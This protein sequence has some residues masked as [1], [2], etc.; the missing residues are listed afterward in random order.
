M[1]SNMNVCNR[2]NIRARVTAK[3]YRKMLLV[4]LLY[5]GEDLSIDSLARE[6]GEG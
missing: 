2:A 4:S 6:T 3:R 1:I 5:I